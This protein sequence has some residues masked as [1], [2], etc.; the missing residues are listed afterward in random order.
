MSSLDISNASK[1]V[2]IGRNYAKH[3]KELNNPIPSEPLLFIKP[4]TTLC[5][6]AGDITIPKEH[7]EVHHELEIAF[8]IG[9]ELK[10]ATQTQALNAISGIGLAIDLTLRDLQTQLKE[11]KQ[12]WEKAKSFD[13]ACPIEC[14]PFKPT[15]S[16]IA[17]LALHFQVNGETK[18]HGTTDLMLFKPLELI[19]YISQWFT[20]AAGDIVLTGT[21][22]GVA[23]L[24]NGDKLESTLTINDAEALKVKSQ[25]I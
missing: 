19:A 11:K 16:D 4:N 8:V 6:L 1:I 20:L 14:L 12:P 15:K 24:N 2:C 25:V 3:A 23:A 10:N 13:G 17:Q 7:G 22:A 18:Q 9:T 5:P 21:P